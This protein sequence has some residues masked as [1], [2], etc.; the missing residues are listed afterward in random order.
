MFFTQKTDQKYCKTSHR[1]RARN[2]RR[3]LSGKIEGTKASSI[4]VQ[5][6]ERD[7]VRKIVALRRSYDL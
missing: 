5:L 6:Y 3:A 1:R 2:L 4:E 7:R